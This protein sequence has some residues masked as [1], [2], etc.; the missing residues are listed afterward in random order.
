M[1]DAQRLLDNNFSFVEEL[2]KKYGEFYP[3]AS[4]IRADDNIVQIGT[5]DGD[6]KPLSD[7]LIGDLKKGLRAKK[8]NYKS[9]IIYYDVRVASPFSEQKTDAIAA[10]FESKYEKTAYVF[11][12]PYLLTKEREIKFFKSWKEETAKEIFDR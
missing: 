5:F 4:A 6:E 2:L 1:S 7:K 8:E 10:Y 9:I 12:C 11:Y 3:L